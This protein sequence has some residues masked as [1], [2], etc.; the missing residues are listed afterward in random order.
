MPDAELARRLL[1]D[2]FPQWA[3]LPLSPAGAGTVH[4]MIRLGDDLVIRLP[5]TTGSG[6]VELEQ[7]WLPVLA[8]RLPLPAPVPVG[9]GEPTSYYPAKWSVQRWLDGDHEFSDLKAC[10]LRLASFLSA[11]REIDTAGA[12]KGY[13]GG[14][15]LVVFKVAHREAPPGTARGSAI[16]PAIS[17]R[18]GRCSTTRAARCS[19]RRPAPT[20]RPGRGAG[21]GRSRSACRPGITTPY[22]TRRSRNSAAARSTVC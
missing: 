3:G 4:V 12:P 1:R 9:F 15:P 2:Q 13:R 22:G 7:R 20:T 10:A 21:R 14:R 16:R 8:P 6:D 19:G 17:C 5:R 18:P 11:L